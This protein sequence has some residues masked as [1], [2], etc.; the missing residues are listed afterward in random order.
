M[1]STILTL[2]PEMF[3]GTLGHSIAGRALEQGLWSCECINIRDFATDKYKTV[4]DKSYGGGTGLV[5]KADVVGTAIE[6]AQ[7][8]NPSARLVYLTPRGVPFTQKVAYELATEDMILLCGRYEGIDQRVLDK[9][10]PLEVSLGDYVLSGGEIAAQVL[11][12]ACIRLIPGVISTPEALENES[13]SISKSKDEASRPSEP[14]AREA[15]SHVRAVSEHGEKHQISAGLLEYPQYS[16]PP[17]WQGLDVP[18]VLLSGNHQAIEA[19]RRSES[20]AI[21]KARRPD[22][23]ES[24]IAEKEKN[25]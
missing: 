4:D 9:Y 12:D 3:P 21:T 25:N 20:E 5:M 24:Y 18:D 1:K 2:F 19:W 17:S 13:F 23:Y 14:S 15:P 22:L 10:Q 16:S 8:Q 6:H 11:L 7:Q